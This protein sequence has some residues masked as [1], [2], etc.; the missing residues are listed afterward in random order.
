[1]PKSRGRTRKHTRRPPRRSRRR[2]T[3]RP[4][5]LA[6]RDQRLLVALVAVD[7][8]EHAGDSA[9]ALEVIGD[10]PAEAEAIWDPAH[11]DRLL[12]IEQLGPLLP[13]WARSRWILAQALRDLHPEVRGIHR[14]ALRMASEL[15]GGLDPV[16]GGDEVD[17]Q[18]Q[19]LDHDWTYRQLVLYEYGGL[20]HFLRTTAAPP[21]VA[22]ADRV[23]EWVD[24]PMRALRLQGRD[25]TRVWWQDLATGE[26]LEMANLGGAVLEQPGDCFLARVVPT[27]SGP[28]LD[29]APLAVSEAIARR[30]A[31][32]PAGWVAALMRDAGTEDY[33]PEVVYGSLLLT[34]V[35]DRI[36]RV[37]LRPF[38][39]P[40]P[41]G[42]GWTTMAEAV[43]DLAR[44]VVAGDPG[45]VVSPH[46][47][48]WPCLAAELLG[49]LV[50][51]DLPDVVQPEDG[52]V[53]VA[54]AERLPE[55]A[56]EVC[57]RLVAVTREA[58]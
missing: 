54:L 9:A 33:V 58:A 52:E 31:R 22:I 8:A 57:R 7:E 32:Q 45:Q 10:Q 5:H 28:M 49:P 36:S 55:P 51:P 14:R 18:V 35:P 2:I 34:D 42:W 20:A 50:L 48:S 37:A 3:P 56:A 46:L 47:D 16:P 44:V 40:G 43:L 4:P 38:L 25:P 27:A 30:V 15:R 11:V 1:M 19:V 41:D 13:G 23:Q 29:G 39:P 26:V 24:A 17:A 53:L 21:L 12:Q 6:D